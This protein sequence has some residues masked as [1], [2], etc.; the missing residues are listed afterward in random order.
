MIRFTTLRNTLSLL[1]RNGPCSFIIVVGKDCSFPFIVF[2]RIALFIC[3]LR[4]EIY[5]TPHFRSAFR[6]MDF[7]CDIIKLVF[8]RVE[9]IIMKVHFDNTLNV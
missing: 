6:L 3:D 7:E 4:Y 2:S 8:E 5:I 1:V 9:F